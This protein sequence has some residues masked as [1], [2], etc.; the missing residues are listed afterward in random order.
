MKRSRRFLVIAHRGASA[1]EPENTLRSFRRA[2]E[3]GADMSELDVH[4]SRDGHL[5]VMHDA[6]VESTTDGRGLIHHM[7]LEQLRQLDA[8]RGERVPTFQEVL[9][10][11]RGQHGLYVELKGDGTPG[12][13]VRALRA[14]AV[15][16]PGQVILGSF[17]P[18]LVREVKSAAPDLRTSIL[19]GEVLGAERLIDLAWAVNA[20]YVHLCWENRHPRPHTLV[21]PALLD[22][23]RGAGL[24]II[25]W[26]EERPEEL[27]YLCGLDVDGICSDAPDRLLQP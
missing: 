12:A 24:G 15:T 14:N 20:D 1:Y 8:G 4:L 22:T 6:S 26:H 21:T 5:I 11:V 7:T 27:G 23:L 16:G 3:L 25:L 2:I 13:V 10:L 17:N 18:S 19:V 9:D